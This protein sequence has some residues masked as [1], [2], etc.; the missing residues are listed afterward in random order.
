MRRGTD[1]G[2]GT[3]ILMVPKRVREAQCVC[4]R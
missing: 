2:Y 3:G 1:E 4:V